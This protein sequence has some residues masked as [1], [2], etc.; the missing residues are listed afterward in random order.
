[1]KGFTTGVLGCEEDQSKSQHVCHNQQIPVKLKAPS[2]HK[3]TH[4]V[5]DGV[6]VSFS[7]IKVDRNFVLVPMLHGSQTLF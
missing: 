5:R 2:D 6:Q 1:M 3:N 7:P 4:N